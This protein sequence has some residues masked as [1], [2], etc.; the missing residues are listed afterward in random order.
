MYILNV[1]DQHHLLNFTCLTTH[2][3][4]I[5]NFIGTD[6]WNFDKRDQKMPN[7]LPYSKLP[8]NLLYLRH[9][10]DLMSLPTSLLCC[11]LQI[12]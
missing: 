1:F 2:L 12:C 6:Y 8:T 9:I 3:N 4:F 11:D 5:F 7:L 10:A